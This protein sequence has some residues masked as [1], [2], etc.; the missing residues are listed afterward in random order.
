MVPREHP[1][2][3][4][5]W[6]EPISD[7]VDEIMARSGRR[8]CVL[9]TGD[10]MWFGIGVTLSIRV[11]V[12]EMVVVPGV[13]A[14]SLA[15][16]RLGWALAD[17]ETLTL[18]GRPLDLLRAYLSPGARILL[19]A[20]DGNSPREVAT[21]LR[22]AGYGDSQVTVFE[23]MAGADERRIEGKANRW[24]KPRAAD[25]NTIAVECRAGANGRSYSRTP[26]LPDDAFLN[27]GQLTKREV[28]AATLAALAPLPGQLLWDVGAG[29]GSIAIEWLRAS[30]GARAIA[31][32]RL[33]ARST[34]IAQN[35][36][37]LGVPQLDIVTGTAPRALA[38]LEAPDAVFIGGGLSKPGLIEACWNAL[39]PGGRLVANAISIEGEEALIRWR[40]RVDGNLTRLAISRAGPMGAYAGWRPLAT[41]TQ[42]AGMKR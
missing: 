10:P 40:K 37:A 7:T 4:L 35:A 17:V 38:G 22:E 24:R 34:L 14:F 6:A 13:S 33:T 28:R 9:A 21:V 2:E 29:C 25:L 15:C 5:V 42:F 27:D 26:G 30:R 32:E 18:H 12:S 41:V 1:A 19:L 31:V 8:V 20:N 3:R 11:P 39:L 36:G 16:A 23:H